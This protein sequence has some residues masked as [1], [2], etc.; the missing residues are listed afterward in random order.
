MQHAIIVIKGTLLPR[1]GKALFSLSHFPLSRCSRVW[2]N[3]LAE[4]RGSKSKLLFRALS[5]SLLSA[6]SF[7]PRSSRRHSPRNKIPSLPAF[8]FMRRRKR[9]DQ[10]ERRVTWAIGTRCPGKRPTLRTFVSLKPGSAFFLEHLF[11]GVNASSDMKV[12]L[13]VGSHAA[14]LCSRAHMFR[15]SQKYHHS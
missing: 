2:I 15:E 8:I 6:R 14:K 5:P 10:E 7:A 1:K 13:G 12:G 9:D 3:L 11:Q 4:K